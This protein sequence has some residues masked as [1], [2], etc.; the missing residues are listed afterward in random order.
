VTVCH[1]NGNEPPCSIKWLA[2]ELLASEE[3]LCPWD[4]SVSQ[5][6]CPSTVI[7]FRLSARRSYAARMIGLIVQLDRCASGSGLVS[8]RLW[9]DSARVAVR[10]TYTSGRS[11]VRLPTVRSSDSPHITTEPIRIKSAP[12]HP[13]PYNLILPSY[14]CIFNGAFPT[15]S[16]TNYLFHLTHNQGQPRA[17]QTGPG[18]HPALCTMGNG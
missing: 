6:A 17:V 8:S 4:L 18:A 12:F 14:S 16:H 9:K 15:F 2:E 3:W 13:P 1:E 11:L 7:C 10:R 5:P